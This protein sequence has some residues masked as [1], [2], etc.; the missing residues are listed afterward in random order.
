MEKTLVILKPDAVQRGIVG[1]IISR[2]EKAGLKIAGAKMFVPSKDLANQHYPRDRKEFIA[3]IGQRTKD[4][5]QELGLDVKKQFGS[6]DPH[7]IGLDVHS[8]LVDFISSGPVMA[9]VLEAPHAISVVRK[10]VGSTAPAGAA[11]GTIRGDYSFDSPSLANASNR[12]II[13][14]VHASGNAQ[15]AEYEVGLWFKSG[16]LFDYKTVHQAHMLE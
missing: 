6:D 2:F 16:E 1:E 10:I 12:P 8:W 7:R 9:L 15:E 4:G 3:G 11:P 5:Y 14:L 13:N